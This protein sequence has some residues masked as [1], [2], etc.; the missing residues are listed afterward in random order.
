MTLDTRPDYEIAAEQFSAELVA[1]QLDVVC[2]FVPFA[3]SRNKDD[4]S[5]SLN[6][7]CDVTRKGRVIMAGVQYTQG[8]GHAPA[9]KNAKRWGAA[10]TALLICQRA[11]HLE[12]ATGFIA[13]PDGQGGVRQSNK[14]LPPPSDVDIIS[15]LCSDSEVLDYATFDGWASEYGYDADSI[16]AKRMYRICLEQ[17]LAIRAALSDATLAK[18]SVLSREL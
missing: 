15:A 8:I 16:K 3:Q 4:K 1:L 17:A 11:E 12:A 13:K 14:P 18:L 10:G 2:K 7:L 5:P 6:W 9:H